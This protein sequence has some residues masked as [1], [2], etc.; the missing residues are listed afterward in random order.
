MGQPVLVKAGGV[1]F[2]MEMTDGGG[3][4]TVGLDDA[5]SFDAVR[6]TVEA[7]ATELA[8]VW[9]R[10]RPSEASVEFGLSLTAKTG[11]LTS[12]ATPQSAAA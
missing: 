10:V 12:M 5:W 9:S 4:R 7:V 6:D 8:D 2:F 1:E 11:K 3:P